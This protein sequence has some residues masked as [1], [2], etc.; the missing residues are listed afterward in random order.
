[1]FIPH[2]RRHHRHHQYVVVDGPCCDI[3]RELF[4]TNSFPSSP[5]SPY[6]TS[7]FLCID[8]RMGKVRLFL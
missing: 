2:H 6:Y 3:L 4:G 5:I 7:I 8:F 1:M